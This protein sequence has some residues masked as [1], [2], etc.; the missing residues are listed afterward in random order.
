MK[1]Y[2]AAYVEE[3]ER[4]KTV[5]KCLEDMGHEITVDWTSFPGSSR[6]ERDADPEKPKAIAVRDMQG[7]RD[8]DVFILLSEPA[9]GRAKYA[10]LGAAIFSA[11]ESKRP[12]IYVLG[13]ETNQSVFFYHPT[14]RRVKTLEAILAE[15]AENGF[16]ASEHTEKKR[17]RGLI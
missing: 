6:D 10:E 9:D 5:Q 2:I 3:V 16:T 8:C 12:K 17:N 1:F 15:N 11:M 7:V 13:K 4:V 14:V